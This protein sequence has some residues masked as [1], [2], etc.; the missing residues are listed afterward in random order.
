MD[1]YPKITFET[2]TQYH[3]DIENNPELKLPVKIQQLEIQYIRTCRN[4]E[5]KSLKGTLNR[6]EFIE[7]I[8]RVARSA[9]PTMDSSLSLQIVIHAYLEQNVAKTSTIE[10]TR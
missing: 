3:R 5:Q 10:S 9:Y 7:Y 1:T 4:Q 2:N 8:V 6:S